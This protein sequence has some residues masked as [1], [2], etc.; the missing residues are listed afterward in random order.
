[1]SDLEVLKRSVAECLKHLNIED[2]EAFVEDSEGVVYIKESGSTFDQPIA[3]IIHG[4]TE[5]KTIARTIAKD[6]WS[7]YLIEYMPPTRHLPADTKE[8][9]I[10]D[11]LRPRDAAI[12]CVLALVRTE[13]QYRLD[14][15]AYA[16]EF[17]DG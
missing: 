3:Y 5:V 9:Y 13:L 16:K 7:V 12:E 6:S 8:R 15:L 11:T 10:A 14:L 2:L 17:S 4:S 1:M